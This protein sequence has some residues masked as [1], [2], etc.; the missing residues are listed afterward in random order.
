MKPGKDGNIL[1]ED[2]TTPFHLTKLFLGQ[3]K[4]VKENWEWHP[5]KEVM[6]LSEQRYKLVTSF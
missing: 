5:M 3:I 1:L 6:A 2:M 4:N